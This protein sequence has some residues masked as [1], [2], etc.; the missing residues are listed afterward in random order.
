MKK[1]LPILSICL[2]MGMAGIGAGQTAPT[3]AP[4]PG[5]RIMPRRN[6]PERPRSG[7]IARPVKPDG[8]QPNWQPDGYIP[9]VPETAAA[10]DARAREMF[11]TAKGLLRRRKPDEA[12]LVLKKLELQEP[13]RFEV[14]HLLGVTYG[15]LRR[16]EDAAASFLKA[17][18]FNTKS[19]DSFSGL[20][21]MLAETGRR[22][23]AVDACRE[24]IRL[25]PERLRFRTQLAEL[26]LFDERVEE[27]IRL[28][29]NDRS[30]QNELPYLGMLG[31][32]YYVNSEYAKAAQIYEKIRRGWPAV[33]IVYLRL[34]GVYD[35]L[36]RPAEAIAAARK[37]A[38]MES[39]L[40]MAHFNL[41][42][43]FQS[44]GF[45]FES[46]D[47]LVKTVDLDRA[48]GSAYLALSESY[49]TV[50]DKEN[51]L[52]SL[53]HAYKYLP[54]KTFELSYRY[55]KALAEDGYREE[56][57]EP[58]ERAYAMRPHPETMRALG[59]AYIEVKQYDK[60]V[61]LIEKANELS[62]LPPGISIDL[63]RI[64]KRDQLLDR[65]DQ[66]VEEVRRNPNSLKA[67]FEAQE[68]YLFKGMVKEAELHGLEMLRLAPDDARNWNGMGI[69]YAN[70]GQIE[71]ALEMTRKAIEL[72]PHHVL[73]ITASFH[74]AKLGRVDEAIE[75]LK[76]SIS[77]KPLLE[78][79]L[80][81]G[82]LWLKKGNRQEALRE[83]QAGL[84]LGPNDIRPNFRL[85]WLY[86]RMGDKD[87]ALRQYQSLQAIA[88]DQVGAL[89]MAIRAHFRLSLP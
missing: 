72:N 16:P 28:L 66:I 20:C 74:L 59:F 88:P 14:H 50:G 57:V 73:Y 38:E 8:K 84:Q 56:A 81:L 6:Q 23:E 5:Q 68:I 55:G 40:A 67:H 42:M 63:T 15:M 27:A 22:I 61:E 78:S 24:A 47:S 77:I 69:F 48:N 45:F 80:A 31:D 25:A 58:L 17:T 54:E 21:F 11:E 79:H 75:A 9:G 3:A 26:Y 85:A 52:G 53:R 2:L 18:I 1:L 89:K 37:F 83:F 32:A 82:D 33:S 76:K 46:I 60:G 35:Y 51:A 65:F 34:A 62:P 19:A 71:K 43:V 29:E 49:E 64:K 86:V 39:T 4:T 7:Q 36:E 41:G 30:S 70:N 44:S 13:K 10:A 87:G 12:L